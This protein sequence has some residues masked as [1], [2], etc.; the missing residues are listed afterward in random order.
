MWKR[1]GCKKNT[2]IKTKGKFIIFSQSLRNY[3]KL[4]EIGMKWNINNVFKMYLN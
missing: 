1:E 3:K 2:I 4:Y